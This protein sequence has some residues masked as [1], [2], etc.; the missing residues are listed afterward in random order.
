M[1]RQGNGVKNVIIGDGFK[2]L[3]QE[4][5]KGWHQTEGQEKKMTSAD[6]A[7][8][9]EETLPPRHRQLREWLGNTVQEGVKGRH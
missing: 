5:V 6:K 9:K 2:N 3:L 8:N 4:E 7:D 1:K